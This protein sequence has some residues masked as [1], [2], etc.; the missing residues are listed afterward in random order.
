[1]KYKFM[2][3]VL[4]YI[5]ALIFSIFSIS[6]FSQDINADAS[7]N[8]YNLSDGLSAM[9]VRSI[10]QD[11]DGFIWVGTEDGLNKFDG[12]NFKIY[13]FERSDTASLSDN[14]IYGLGM[15]H[16]GGIWVGTNNGGLNRYNPSTDNFTRYINDPDDKYSLSNNRVESIFQSDSN[17]VWVGT[18]GGGLN[19]LDLRTNR[20]TRYM[21]DSTNANGITN[22]YVMGITNDNYGILWVRT[23]IDLLRF[24]PRDETFKSFNIP[25]EADGTLSYQ[26]GLILHDKGT[27]WTG[28]NEGLVKVNTTT[29]KVQFIKIH[30]DTT[31]D[32]IATGLYPHNENSIWVSSASGLFLFNKTN[33]NIIRFTNDPLRASSIK[34]DGGLCVHKDFTGSVWVGIVNDG[35]SKLNTLRKKFIHY[36]YDPNNPDYSLSGNT[37]RSVYVD[38]DGKYWAMVIPHTMNVIDPITG[39]VSKYPNFTP[40]SQQVNYMYE[41]EEDRMWMACWLDG[42]LISSRDNPTNY[43]WLRNDPSNPN[44]LANNIVQAILV[45]EH[46]VAWFGHEGGIDQYNTITKEFRHFAYDPE[47][48]NSICPGGVQTGCVIKD[49]FGNYWVGHWGGLSMMTPKVRS[50]STFDTEYRVHRFR[51]NPD[52]LNSLSDNRIISIH[53]NK[54]KYPNLLFAGTY[55]AGFNVIE[56]NPQKPEESI[57]TAYTINEGLANNVVYGMLSDKEGNVWLSTN[58]GL[59]K[60]NPETKE[61]SNFDVNDGLQS[62]QFF[63]GAYAKGEEGM[64]LF[65]GVNGLN[66]FY[67]DEIMNDQT[68]P[69]VVLTDFKVL[70]ESVPVG[71]KVNGR[72]LISEVINKTNY[73]KLTH[74]ENVFSFEFSGLHY[75]FP[76]DNL[77]RYIMEGFDEDWFE[78]D[79]KQRFASYTNLNAGKYVFKV[80]A[81]NY[82]GVWNETPKTINVRI[83]PPWWKTWW[84]YILLGIAIGLAI[85]AYFKWRQEQERRDKEILEKKIKEGEALINQKMQEVEEHEA[86]MKQRDIEEQEI[87]FMSEG[88]AKF[89]DI[90]A[91]NSGDLEKLSQ[92]VIAEIVDYLGANMG[93]VYIINDA[94]EDDNL[95]LE[96]SGSFAADRKVLETK[97]FEIGEGYIGTCFKNGEII[98]INEVPEDFTRL[99]SGLGKGSPNHFFYIPLKQN[100]IT[101]GVI[102]IASFMKIEEFK[103]KFVEKIAENITSVITIKKTSDKTREMLERSNMQAEEL[104][105]Q[106]EEMR[107]NLEELMATQEEMGRKQDAWASE[108]SALKTEVDELKL[109]IVKLEKE[110]EEAKGAAQ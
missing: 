93:V 42:V 15:A 88:I 16:D 50:I 89:S 65:G 40:T 86:E 81:S 23:G 26:A 99:T 84:F 11:N 10:I 71:K 70:N 20:F 31:S 105:A 43:E 22:D 102:E 46:G 97:V 59:S 19:K 60:F 7:F 61:F 57:I 58:G 82:D 63:W 68:L 72:V 44:S 73:V 100:E 25:G 2:D 48:D 85:Y 55:G 67:P 39:L 47:D 76:E 74:K 79:S 4:R 38:K 69:S 45:D 6:S 52:D 75:A 8:H 32:F 95:Q 28:Y 62:N 64:L 108:K 27:I 3:E 41:D 78:V 106:E 51:N 21:Y 104:Q 94:M 54:E 66:T 96:V 49:A 17:T 9:T 37:I 14:F 35:I 101:Q 77:Y 53:Y 29:N 92:N 30:N 12:Y 103:I 56:F 90:L 109:D 98:S 34:A 18:N 80:Q 33:N 107:Q 13:R 36:Y 83:V 91:S 110:L 1:M 24:D 87:R 5:I